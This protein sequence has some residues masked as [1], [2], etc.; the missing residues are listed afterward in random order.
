MKEISHISDR[1]RDEMAIGSY[2]H[3]NPLIRWLMW[4][5]YVQIAHFSKFRADMV[6]LEFGCGTGVFL[7]ELE[8][9]C[10]KVFA[11]DRFPEY[12]KLLSNEFNLKVFFLDDVS[13][14]PTG[15][16]DIIIAADVLEHL[17]Y[18][19]LIGYLQIFSDKL[20]NNG[21]LIISGPTENFAYKT[22]RFLAGFN[23]NAEYHR[24]NIDNLIEI[25]NRYFYLIRKRTLPF[26]FP[27]YIFKVCEFRNH[28]PK[29]LTGMEQ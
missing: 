28:Q 11:I 20:K 10:R 25:I 29:P 16:L 6:V 7:K 19:D 4:Q 26:S 3:W 5:R 2:L 1:D 13:E 8:S 14:I 23:R 17:S 24:R 27:P 9:R 15:S 22:G 21:R 18:S 12:A